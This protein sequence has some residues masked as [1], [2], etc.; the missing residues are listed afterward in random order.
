MNMLVGDSIQVAEVEEPLVGE[1]ELQDGAETTQHHGFSVW[2]IA[3]RMQGCT[4]Q[5][6]DS[7]VQLYLPKRKHALSTR[8]DTL[9]LPGLPGHK[10]YSISKLDKAYEQGYFK[11]NQYLH[12]ELTVTGQG[13]SAVPLPYRLWR[14]DYVTSALLICFLIL[15]Y[16]LNR[17][18]KQLIQQAKDF[19]RA[20]REHEG[21]F[22]T[23]TTFETHA[24]LF[25][26]VQLSLLGGLLSFAYAQY[27][28]DLFLGQV[29]PYQLLTI[30]VGCFLIYFAVRRLLAGFVHW[31]FFE[32][33]QQK[34]WKD[35]Y[36]FLITVESAIFFPLALIFVYFNIS[37]IQAA[38]VLGILL[39]ILKILLLYKC[40]SIFFHNFYCLFHLFAYLCALELMP[41]LALIKSLLIVTDSLIIKF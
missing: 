31:V 2:R 29:S 30:Y 3:Q 36:N 12:P 5:Q 28:L 24:S 10:A 20:P 22:A 38:W 19:F 37:I 13:Y 21:L 18:R 27:S 17:T 7:V 6:L 33:T 32:K 16:V 15:V 41:I 34:Q 25:M 40:Y 39:I 11:D 23:K 26:V 8:P 35:S 1:E 9:S 14:D 4:P